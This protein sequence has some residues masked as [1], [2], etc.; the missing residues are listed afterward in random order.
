M[1]ITALLAEIRTDPLVRGY[2]TKTQTAQYN[3]LFTA[4]RT[5]ERP[6]LTG[7]QIY[8]CVVPAE[9]TALTAGNQQIVRDITG[10]GGDI[11][12]QTGTNARNALLNVFGAGT[13][14]R[15]NIGTAVNQAITRAE[16]LNCS[17]VTLGYFIYLSNLNSL[18]H[19]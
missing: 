6:T 4:Y 9:F 3:D 10:L 16:E 15:T 11:N 5:R 12:L 14:T 19:A 18:P 2:S 7:A 13:T 8:N 17:D 1:D